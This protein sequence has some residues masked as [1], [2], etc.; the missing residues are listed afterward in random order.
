MADALMWEVETNTALAP[1]FL[2]KIKNATE[3][4]T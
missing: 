2:T 1:V 4:T 3:I